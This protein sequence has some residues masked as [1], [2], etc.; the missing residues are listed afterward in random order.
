MALNASMRSLVFGVRALLAVSSFGCAHAD[1]AAD[2]H[3]TEMRHSLDKLQAERDR[4]SPPAGDL[5]GVDAVNTTPPPSPA[6]PSEPAGPERRL[7]RTVSID[8]EPDIGDDERSD[9]VERP[10]IRLVGRSSGGSSGAPSRSN[11]GKSRIEI[12]DYAGSEEPRASILDP[13]AKRSYDAALALAQSKQCP[14]AIEAFGV[15]M[16]TW[17][18]H[19]YVENALYWSGECHASIGEPARAVERFEAMLE[20]FG[21]GN[22]APD[23]LLKLGQCHERLGAHERARGAWERLRRDHPRSEA[24]RKIPKS[25]EEQ[26]GRSPGP[27]EER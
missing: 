7:S 24:A 21:S 4:M 13:E 3:L 18:D 1:A 9:A 20:R 25:G 8:G 22:K 26:R 17:P 23:A 14:K 19:P 16:A 2:R 6:L 10:T 15:F 11:R 5:D 12:I 27:K